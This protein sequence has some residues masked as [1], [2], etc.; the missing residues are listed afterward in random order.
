MA[1]LQLEKS[2]IVMYVEGR[3]AHRVKMVWRP[4]LI[5]VSPGRK[6]WC[7]YKE[8]RKHEQA[9]RG[10]KKFLIPFPKHQWRQLFWCNDNNGSRSSYVST[11]S[12][13]AASIIVSN[14]SSETVT[15][16]IRSSRSL[17]LPFAGLRHEP[18][19]SFVSDL[20]LSKICGDDH[21]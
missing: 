19:N 16:N 1:I 17:P 18:P 14:L 9:N 13:C 10:M 7:T 8:S 6:R 15:K 5:F 11:I 20:R 12:S 4:S 21:V 3:E 2:L